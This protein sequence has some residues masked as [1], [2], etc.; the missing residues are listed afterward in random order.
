M[1]IILITHTHTCACRNEELKTLNDEILQLKLKEGTDA[2]DSL[3]ASKSLDLS[4]TL[5]SCFNA[6]SFPVSP[7]HKP[8]SEDDV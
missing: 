1:T 7:V 2:P 5:N 4:F 6:L 3:R 8:M